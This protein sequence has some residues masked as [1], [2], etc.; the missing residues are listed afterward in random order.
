MNYYQINHQRF[1]VTSAKLDKCV[2]RQKTFTIHFALVALVT[3]YRILK[4]LKTNSNRLK[5]NIVVPLFFVNLGQRMRTK[6]ASQKRCSYGKL[7]IGAFSNKSMKNI[8]DRN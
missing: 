3:F 8:N 1:S 7:K 2:E 6:I 4:H 5:C